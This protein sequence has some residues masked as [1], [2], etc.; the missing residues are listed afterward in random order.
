MNTKTILLQAGVFTLSALIGWGTV[1]LVKGSDEKQPTIAELGESSGSSSGGSSSANSGYG[2]SGSHDV[3]SDTE[4]TSKD[5][6]ADITAEL[7]GE[8]KTQTDLMAKE[9]ANKAAEA[10]A[11][12]K[13]AEQKAKEDAKKKAEA[14]N[15]P[16]MTNA[17]LS[18][19]LNDT[20]D[21]SHGVNKGIPRGVSLH[22]TNLNDDEVNPS[23]VSA[24]R[25][26]IKGRSWTSVTVTGAQFKNGKV[27]SITYRA[28]HRE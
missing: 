8:S 17:E 3:N 26:N 12:A 25:M 6:T 9:S 7:Q 18:A 23:S 13:E 15:E 19:I 16:T 10:A 5:R 11:K 22:C 20:G 24:I 4:N 14:A 21:S 28:N 1:T 27:V 2:N